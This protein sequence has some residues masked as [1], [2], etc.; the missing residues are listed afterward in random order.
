MGIDATG[1]SSIQKLTSAYK[2][3]DSQ[4]AEKEDYL[5][6]E[7]FLT[8][9]VA[10]LQNQDPLNPMEGSEF[11]AQLAQF[12][13][14]EQL[15]NMNESLE[16]MVTAFNDGSDID[17]SDF[18]GK[19]V[20]GTV[21]SIEVSDGAFSGGY[22]DLAQ[23][24]DVM[25]TIYDEEGN[26]VKNL[27]PGQKE[28]G[29]HSIN[30]DG[31]DNSGNQVIDGSYSYDVLA[32]SGYGYVSAPMTVTG[33]VE[34]V[35]YQNGKPYL[36]VDGMLVDPDSLVQ[37]KASDEEPAMSPLDYLGKEVSYSESVVAV[38]D[39]EVSGSGLTFYLSIPED[40]LVQVF[41]ASGNEVNN[42][43]MSVDDVVSG[44]NEILWGGTDSDG[45]LVPD[46]IYSYKVTGSSGNV[47]ISGTGEVSGIKYINGT[48]YLTLA[49]SGDIVRISSITGVN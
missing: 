34:A 15:I 30:W 6:R 27:Y 12:S 7:D 42:T 13:S 9:L 43:E 21:N 16:S 47:E 11:S 39:G 32:N 36:L 22:Y 48:Q 44:K 26:T 28:A 33:T 29:S 23:T 31:T 14:L 20:T 49:G 4:K 10:Q 45:N 18:I 24:S 17:V 1:S 46:G 5:G 37:I 35:T 25:V 2:T 3:D 8:M 40:V 41:D 19:E 38:E